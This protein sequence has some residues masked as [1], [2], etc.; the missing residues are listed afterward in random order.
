MM[1]SINPIPAV[2]VT[3]AADPSSATRRAARAPAAAPAADDDAVSVDVSAIPGS[4]P[5]EVLQAMGTAA[6]A[7]DRLAATGRHLHFASDPSTGQLSVQVT[8]PDGQLLGTVSASTVL[9]IAA[10]EPLP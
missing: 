1:S 9:G 10:G 3:A 6:G 2:P 4:P 7:Y 8:D 5:D